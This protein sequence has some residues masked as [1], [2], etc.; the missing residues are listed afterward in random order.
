M[1]DIV[2]TAGPMPA[3]VLETK[4]AERTKVAI[5]V[6]KAIMADV[7]HEGVLA[8]TARLRA[9]DGRVLYGT[10]EQIDDIMRPKLNIDAVSTV[11]SVG[12]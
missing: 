2:V 8:K 5:R 1:K 10:P 11:G 3:G 12:S 7:I 9:E 6:V 4:I